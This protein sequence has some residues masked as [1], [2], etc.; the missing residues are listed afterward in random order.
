MGVDVWGR[1]K[2]GRGEGGEWVK[3]ESGGEGGG[4]SFLSISQHMDRNRGVTYK[5]WD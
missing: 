2:W 4:E 5:V 1:G 3:G